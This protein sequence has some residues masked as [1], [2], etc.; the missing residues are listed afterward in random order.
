[1][2]K[3]RKKM[4]KKLKKN[5]KKVELKK[6][7]GAKSVGNGNMVKEKNGNK[8][9]KIKLQNLLMKELMH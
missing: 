4:L 5:L 3:L 2:K 6:I 7:N 1:M 8:N 9:L